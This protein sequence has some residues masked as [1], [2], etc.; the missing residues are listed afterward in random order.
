M[1]S[2]HLTWIFHTR[3]KGHTLV[4]GKKK[5]QSHEIFFMDFRNN[6]WMQEKQPKHVPET[7]RATHFSLWFQVKHRVELLPNIP[8]FF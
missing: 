1:L 4:A 2:W 8:T 5:H 3:E 7:P 6:V